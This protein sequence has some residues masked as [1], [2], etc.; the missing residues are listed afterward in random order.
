VI[1]IR[2]IC[3]PDKE[4]E[5]TEALRAG[6]TLASL[7]RLPSRAGDSVRLYATA[8]PRAADTATPPTPWQHVA[9]VVA[10]LNAHN[11]TG[12]TETALRLIKLT[13]E[14]GE[15]MQA[16]IGATGQNPRKGTTH[17]ADDVTAELCDVILT[18]MVAL[19]SFTDDPETTFAAVV[20]ARGERLAGLFSAA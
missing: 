16:Y 6:F 2:A 5:V 13:E 18:A 17:T 3:P 8:T 4:P 14:T 9:R 19:H 15:V 11:G 1:E 7:R 10:W 12:P 20:Q